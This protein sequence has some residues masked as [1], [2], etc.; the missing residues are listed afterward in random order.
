[1]T[2]I[3]SIFSLLFLIIITASCTN[4]VVKIDNSFN[5]FFEDEGVQGSFALM[6]NQKGI[7]IL[8]DLKTDTQ[9]IAPGNA[10]KIAAVLVGIETHKINDVN[11]KMPSADGDTT[12]AVTLK[13]AFD[14][15]DADY[16]SALTK[17]IGKD[18]M[19][20]WLDSLGY[21]NANVSDI[22]SFWYN[23]ELE[24]SPDE[25]MGLLTK[26]YFDKLPFQKYAQGVVRELL[27]KEDNTKYRYSYTTAEPVAGRGEGWAMGWIE[28]NKHV[29]FFTCVVKNDGGQEDLGAKAGKIARAILEDQGYFKGEK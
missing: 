29:Y 6:N 10:F 15:N 24:V 11:T 26:I 1:M 17:E 2:R 25:Q 27:L 3:Y 4:N 7:V 5:K 21:G 19:A 20:F 18:R 28:E 16:F 9:R 8:N 12:A 22:A 13:E 14:N 23:G